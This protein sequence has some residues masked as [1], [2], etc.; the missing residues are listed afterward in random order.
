MGPLLAI[1]GVVTVAVIL[2]RYGT[3]WAGGRPIG[4]VLLVDVG[5]GIRL[6][7]PAAAAFKAMRAAAASA[8]VALNATSGYRTHERQQE[9][10]KEYVE[11]TR[12][13]QVAKP[14]WSRHESGVAVDI[15]VQRS[16]SSPAFLWLAAHARHYGF[17]DTVA[18]EPWHWEFSGE[19]AA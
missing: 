7:A 15:E 17:R 14:G 16:R 12:K 2:S 19:K 8:S 4:A 3:A 13:D 5:G 18:A 9:L 6:A 10:Y 1:A 11:G